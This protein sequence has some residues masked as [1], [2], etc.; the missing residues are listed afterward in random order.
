VQLATRACAITK[1]TEPALIGT[2]AAA[3]AETGDFDKAVIAA[4][5]AH[6]LAAAQGAKA[7]AET[8]Q[9]LIAFYRAHKPFREKK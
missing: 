4:Q 8:N 6:D 2:L 3:Y 1:G 9:E 7:L 5:K